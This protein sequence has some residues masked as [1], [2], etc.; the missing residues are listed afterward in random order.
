MVDE[1]KHPKGEWM[2]PHKTIRG[3]IHYNLKGHHGDGLKGIAF[4]KLKSEQLVWLRRVTKSINF[5]LVRPCRTI[6]QQGI[7]GTFM[8]YNPKKIPLEKESI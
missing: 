2:A 5:D 4:Q 8:T 7:K 6:L 3:R 1:H